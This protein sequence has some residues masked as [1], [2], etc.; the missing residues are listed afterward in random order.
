MKRIVCVLFS[1]LL[2]TSCLPAFAG[3]EGAAFRSPQEVPDAVLEFFSDRSFE[4][5]AI[6]WRTGYRCTLK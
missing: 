5:C 1:L 4:G 3:T 6:G 2:L